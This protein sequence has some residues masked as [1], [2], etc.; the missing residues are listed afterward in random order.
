[1]VAN[2][3]SHLASYGQLSNFLMDTA[4]L[5]LGQK[6]AVDSY[7]NCDG[8]C[9]QQLPS[10]QLVAITTKRHGLSASCDDPK[11]AFIISM[12]TPLYPRESTKL[13]YDFTQTMKSNYL[14]F[15]LK[16]NSNYC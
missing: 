16:H 8:R 6:H 12:A 1:M 13:I 14:L 9:R 3:N 10:G 5:S 2:A 4:A 11:T 7:Q 15:I